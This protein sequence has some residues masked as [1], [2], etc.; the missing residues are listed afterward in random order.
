MGVRR[1]LAMIAGA[2]LLVAPAVAQ[3]D[4]A[5]AFQRLDANGDGVIAFGELHHEG[6]DASR[7]AR[8][9]AGYVTDD[10]Y[11]V[12]LW[13]T[14]FGLRVSSS[15]GM[16]LAATKARQDRTF[17]RD[18]P[19]RLAPWLMLAGNPELRTMTAERFERELR[20]FADKMI[21]GLDRDG[22]E[23]ISTVEVDRMLL[24]VIEAHTEN[25]SFQSGAGGDA[26]R[27]HVH[28]LKREYYASLDLDGDGVFA[29]DEMLES[30]LTRMV[31]AYALPKP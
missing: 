11:V 8:P 14:P 1:Y 31:A 15:S 21:A 23:G 5:A 26:M 7:Y 22:D 28:K 16:T 4:F 9:I 20:A 29:A 2:V 12:E 13:H 18:V 24:D 25:A 27:A 10:G 6:V 30:V 17:V 19:V 3:P